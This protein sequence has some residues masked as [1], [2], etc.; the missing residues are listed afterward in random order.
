LT[1]LKLG[2]PLP[3]YYNIKKVGYKP[4]TKSGNIFSE[5]YMTTP[6][7]TRSRSKTLAYVPPVDV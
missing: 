3:T 7:Q 6:V 1:I 4:E 5:P 2:I